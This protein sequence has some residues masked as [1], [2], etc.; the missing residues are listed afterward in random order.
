MYLADIEFRKGKPLRVWLKTFELYNSNFYL[1]EK[2]KLK[3]DFFYL[4][5]LFKYLTISVLGDWVILHRMDMSSVSN[6][7]LINKLNGVTDS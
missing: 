5:E 3:H 1:G 7:L 2:T 6:K 4:R